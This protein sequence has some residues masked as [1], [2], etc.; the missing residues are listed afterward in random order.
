MCCDQDFGEEDRVKQSARGSAQSE[1]GR[2]EE[3]ERTA[4]GRRA[5]RRET[6]RIVA[7]GCTEMQHRVL[8]SL[9]ESSRKMTLFCKV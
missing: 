8:H 5:Q 3:E 1:E 4:S 7:F 6:E 9:E 2:V